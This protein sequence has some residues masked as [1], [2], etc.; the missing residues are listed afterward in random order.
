[1][2][3]QLDLSIILVPNRAQGARCLHKTLLNIRASLTLC[4]P[5]L[6]HEFIVF[7]ASSLG[8]YPNDYKTADL[9]IIDKKE[10]FD[11]SSTG[12]LSLVIEEGSLVTT[13][14]LNE[15]I[16]LCTAEQNVTVHTQLTI[17]RANNLTWTKQD[18]TDH[19]TLLSLPIKNQWDLP[20][21]TQSSNLP[22]DNPLGDLWLYNQNSL[23]SGVAHVVIPQSLHIS[24][25]EPHPAIFPAPQ[26][27]TLYTSNHFRNLEPIM[28]VQQ[29]RKVSFNLATSKEILRKIHVRAK[30]KSRLYRAA[31]TPLLNKVNSKTFERK[32]PQWAIDDWR[33]IHQFDRTTFP[34]KDIL[35]A[36]AD[37]TMLSVDAGN[38]FLELLKASSDK[39]PDYI[40]MSQHMMKGGGDKV[41]LNYINTMSQLR[42]KWSIMLV[43]TE[44][45]D[46]T[47]KT[48]VP[49][50]VTYVDFGHIAADLDYSLKQILLARFTVQTRCAKFMLAMTP[51]G[52]EMIEKYPTVF[53]ASNYQIDSVA[54]CSDTDKFDRTWGIH[55][56]GIPENFNALHKIV[57]DNEHVIDETLELEPLSRDK[58]STHY[59]PV[60]YT[61][62]KPLL[63]KNEGP[64]R[65]LW[66]SRVANQ[67]RPDIVK[68]IA[69]TLDPSEYQIHM[70]G[71]L[72]DEYTTHDFEGVDTLQY[73]GGFNG[74]QSIDTASY[75]VLLYTSS[76]DG[77]PNILL[78]A[79]ALGL[80]IVAP[81]VGGVGEF[82]IDRNTGLLI[83]D[84]EDIAGFGAALDYIENN[85]S[86]ALAMV[87]SAQKLLV[88]RHSEENFKYSVA[89]D[90]IC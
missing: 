70:Y 35:F 9:R 18:S 28:T 81:A 21:L 44:L 33:D 53:N 11:M 1:M 22:A 87:K 69:A 6:S 72:E 41:I 46:N 34:T 36:L 43:V 17:F 23:A 60:H 49:Q 42:P 26:Y 31:V 90:L 88:S 40:F 61:L 32:I 8:N 37:T 54:F 64:L 29:K 14:W 48:Q 82:I 58:F 57:T 38:A 84:I 86:K 78:E 67:K 25:A 19:A 12:K 83:K 55:F 66:A 27:S 76:F 85:P 73:K 79:T 5:A 16:S 74:L 56:F 30:R 24:H 10:S 59:Q 2:V 45:F 7:E 47:W 68:K 20:L 80:P 62:S 4:K 3:K 77:V 39:T 65:V 52:F 13:G 15:A 75:D 63:R 71:N 89:K 51:F 50:D